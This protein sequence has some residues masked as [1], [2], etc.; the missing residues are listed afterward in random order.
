MWRRNF[1][2][3]A[4]VCAMLLATLAVATPSLAAELIIDNSDGSVQVKGQWTSTKSTTGFYGGD[5]LFRTAG[6]GSTSVTWP[7][8][9][10]GAA[11]RYAVFAQWSGGPNR[12]SNA[13]YQVTSAAG[14]ANVAVNQKTNGGSWQSLGTFDFTPNKGQGVVLTNKADGVVVADAIRFVGPQVDA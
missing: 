5:Y 10:S 1:K 2:S 4:L 14:A 12:A 3:Y 11:G 8:P 13:T 9:S 7:F 6:D